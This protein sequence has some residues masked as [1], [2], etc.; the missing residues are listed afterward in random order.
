[1]FTHSVMYAN[2]N[3]R[4]LLDVCGNKRRKM[5]NRCMG[6]DIIKKGHSNNYYLYV[7]E[8]KSGRED[9]PNE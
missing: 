8:N 4:L 7:K 1:M 3:Y 6:I 5:N 2:P 9:Y